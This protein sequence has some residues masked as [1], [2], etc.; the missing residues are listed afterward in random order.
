MVSLDL[1]SLPCIATYYVSLDTVSRYVIGWCLYKA[2]KYYICVTVGAT[3][4]LPKD[5]AEGEPPRIDVHFGNSNKFQRSREA[6]RGHHGE[7]T[8]QIR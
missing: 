2:A 6:K 5:L 1:G 4:E 3:G 7:V 8:E